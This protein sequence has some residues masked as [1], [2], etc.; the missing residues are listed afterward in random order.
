MSDPDCPPSCFLELLRGKDFQ[1]LPTVDHPPEEIRNFTRSDGDMRVLL[2]ERHLRIGVFSDG[3]SGCGGS[4]GCSSYDCNTHG[5]S[6][7]GIKSVDGVFVR[8]VGMIVGLRFEM[9]SY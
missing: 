7:I 8:F 2:V 5:S 4:G 6:N 3:L 9:G 1:F